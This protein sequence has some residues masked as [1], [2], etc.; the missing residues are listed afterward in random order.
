MTV[1][2]CLENLLYILSNHE[3]ADFDIA[4]KKIVSYFSDSNVVAF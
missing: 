4:P 1:W 2:F 3:T